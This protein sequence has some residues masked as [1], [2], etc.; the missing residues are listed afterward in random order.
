MAAGAKKIQIIRH[1]ISKS[2][3]QYT[4]AALAIRSSRKNNV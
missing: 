4:L 2:N 3:P 1:P